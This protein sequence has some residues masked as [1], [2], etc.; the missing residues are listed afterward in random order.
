MPDPDV[1]TDGPGPDNTTPC[2]RWP[3]GF[4]STYF[5]FSNFVN[6]DE[7]YDKSKFCRVCEVLQLWLSKEG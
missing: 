5:Q 2:P 3:F 7:K 6:A 1:P 4:L